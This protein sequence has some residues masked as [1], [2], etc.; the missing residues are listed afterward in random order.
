[1]PKDIIAKSKFYIYG[2]GKSSVELMDELPTDFLGNAYKAGF[3]FPVIIPVTHEYGEMMDS[4]EQYETNPSPDDRLLVYAKMPIN[5]KSMWITYC[6]IVAEHSSKLMMPQTDVYCDEEYVYFIIYKENPD[7]FNMIRDTMKEGIIYFIE[8]LSGI[9]K[10]TVETYNQDIC[11]ILEDYICHIRGHYLDNEPSDFRHTFVGWHFIFPTK[12]YEED[13][14]FKEFIDIFSVLQK[15]K[16][17]QYSSKDN[18]LMNIWNIVIPRENIDQTFE[19]YIDYMIG[20]PE[21]IRKGIIESF[22]ARQYGFIWFI[23]ESENNPY[24]FT[25]EESEHLKKVI[26]DNQPSTCVPIVECTVSDTKRNN[27]KMIMT[28]GSS[29]SNI[30]GA[31]ADSSGEIITNL[32]RKIYYYINGIEEEE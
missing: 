15:Y 1:M 16:Y 10:A 6:H 4:Q 22:L 31:L 24:G 27:Q 12:I 30:E 8:Y 17:G 26:K 7:E 19:A 3:M 13:S 29:L 32:T 2:P 28:F 25:V 20:A 9:K 18:R 5:D 21:A 14:I 11:E 23:S